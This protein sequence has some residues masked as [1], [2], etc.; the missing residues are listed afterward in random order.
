MGIPATGKRVKITGMSIARFENGMLVEGWDE[1]DA[2][3][4]MQQLR[5]VS[6]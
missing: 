3:G 4:L 6:P 1:L 2:L 5:A